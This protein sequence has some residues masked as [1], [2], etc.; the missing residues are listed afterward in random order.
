MKIEGE[1]G[2]TALAP[3]AL[4]EEEKSARR[5]AKVRTI[6]AESR[7]SLKNGKAR[8]DAFAASGAFDDW[9]TRWS[10]FTVG[11]KLKALKDWL[12]DDPRNPKAADER[13]LK[14]IAA[15]LMKTA[16]SAEPA[17]TRDA[18]GDEKMKTEAEIG[19]ETGA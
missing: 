6:A 11:P 5:E 13:R 10:C 15:L 8:G 9:P 1:N 14:S 4:S 2:P 17:P 12:D 7:A 3:A 16:K 19:A 18:G